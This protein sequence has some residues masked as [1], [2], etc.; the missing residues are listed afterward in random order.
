MQ[1]DL[2]RHPGWFGR[3]APLDALVNEQHVASVNAKQD[4]SLSLPYEG[5]D[6]QVVMQGF[7]S[8]HVL[9]VFA[10]KHQF[11]L[12]CGTRLWVFFRLR[13]TVLLAT[14]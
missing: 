8:S 2:Y 4:L 7:V 3:A 5:A 14:L 1:V 10:G 13:I 11:K 9:H 6:L 12:E